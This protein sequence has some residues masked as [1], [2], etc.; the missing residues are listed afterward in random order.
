M[1]EVRLFFTNIE[2]LKILIPIVGSLIIAFI[3]SKVTAINERNKISTM[4]FKQEGVKSQKEILD[5]WSTILIQDYETTIIK[6][7]K[8]YNIN[9]NKNDI[10][11]FKLLMQDTIL[12][13]SKVTATKLANYMQHVYKKHNDND[14]NYLFKNILLTANVIKSLKYDFTGEKLRIIDIIKIKINDLTLV[15][16]LKIRIFQ[17]INF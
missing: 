8:H 5:V 2:Y 6:A 4:H 12:Y 11:V 1:E 9:N 17:I 10:D 15:S 13:C 7:K 16:K 3:T 14:K